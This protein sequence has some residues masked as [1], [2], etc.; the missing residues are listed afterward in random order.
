MVAP[1][2]GGRI[3]VSSENADRDPE[4]RGRGFL[5]RTLPLAILLLGTGAFFAFGL[6]HYLS[7]E[8]LSRHRDTLLAWRA[9]NETLAVLAFI[10]VYVAVTA[11]SIPGAVWMTIAG[12]FLF[13]VVAGSAY[14][15]VGATLGSCAVFLAARFFAGD[16]LRRRAG[17]QVHRMEAG[18]RRHAMSYLL[19]LRLVP[20]FPFWLV[21]LAPALIGVPLR[22]FIV[23]TLLGIVPG[24]VVYASVGNGLSAVIAAGGTP[25]LGVLFHLEVLAPLLGLAAL[26]LVP[27]VYRWLKHRHSGCSGENSG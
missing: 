17:A 1:Q 20:I 25:D 3:E 18:F 23:G 5:W 6:H 14:A 24:S 12:G 13:G 10:G 7:F 22:T 16:W 15:V 9:R 8:E 11:L 19:V 4:A 27:V 2:Q 21:N 26:A